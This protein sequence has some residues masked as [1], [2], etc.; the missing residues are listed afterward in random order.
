MPLKVS[1]QRN[2]KF[3]PDQQAGH[4]ENQERKFKE[5]EDR[6]ERPYTQ[7][8]RGPD[9][10]F[11]KRPK[12]AGGIQKISS[13]LL[14]YSCRHCGQFT[15]KVLH[16]SNFL[17]QCKRCNSSSH[18]KNLS[19]SFR[20]LMGSY[21]CQQQRCEARWVQRLPFKNVIL[22][23][24]VCDRCHKMTKISQIFFNGVRVTFKNSLLYKCTSCSKSKSISLYKATQRARDNMNEGSEQQ[25]FSPNPKCENC[26]IP[27][28]FLKNLRSILFGLANDAPGRRAKSQ[29]PRNRRFEHN[30]K[31]EDLREGSQISM[32]LATRQ[33][34]PD[35]YSKYSHPQRGAFRGRG[36]SRGSFRGSFSGRGRGRGGHNYSKNY[37]PSPGRFAKSHGDSPQEAVEIPQNHIEEEEEV[38]QTSLATLD[39]PESN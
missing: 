33:L 8:R 15:P 20:M 31:N 26:H 35:P 3:N 29:S 9:E 24:P 27:M 2:F 10:H 28:N 39:Q 16:P 21:E 38:N 25:K 32:P 11:Q 37:P 23:T 7:L 13:L 17:Q 14:K 4:R 18:L 30:Q 12:F 19:S 5:R 34:Q 6:G 36:S 1:R 22:N